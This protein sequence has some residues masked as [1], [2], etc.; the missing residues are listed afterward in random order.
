M[1][2][3]LIYKEYIDKGIIGRNKHGRIYIRSTER[4]KEF[5]KSKNILFKEIVN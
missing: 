1:D 2:R 3:Y 5:I 4:D